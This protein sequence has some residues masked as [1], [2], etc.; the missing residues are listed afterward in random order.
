MRMP[1]K[2]SFPKWAM[3]TIPLLLALAVGIAVS[4]FGGR[5]ER[6]KREALMVRLHEQVDNEEIPPGNRA[7]VDMVVDYMLEHS[8][9]TNTVNS[10]IRILGPS[11][12][13]ASTRPSPTTS[14]RSNPHDSCR[15]CSSPSGSA[16]TGGHFG[17]HG[18]RDAQG[19]RRPACCPRRHHAARRARAT[20]ETRRAR[21]QIGRGRQW[22]PLQRLHRPDRLSDIPNPDLRTEEIRKV[23]NQLEGKTLGEILKMLG[24]LGGD[25]ALMTIKRRAGR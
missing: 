19:R 25:A 24:Y 15:A 11:R 8:D 22:Q 6:Q 3:V 4:K 2:P 13:K 7:T 20:A 5:N 14:Q 21:R 23:T 18:V 9:N 10:A 12:G 17:A 1:P 16:V